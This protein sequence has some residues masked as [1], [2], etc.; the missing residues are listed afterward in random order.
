MSVVKFDKRLGRELKN[1]LLILFVFLFSGSLFANESL[2]VFLPD[3]YVSKTD[4]FNLKHAA[5]IYSSGIP[6]YNLAI[7]KSGYFNDPNVLIKSEKPM[8]IR[9]G[10]STDTL[11]LR[12]IERN[13][14]EV[15]K[16]NE[17]LDEDLKADFSDFFLAISKYQITKK[18]VLQMDYEP[19]IGTTI[20]IN[21]NRELLLEGSDFKR[22]FL[23]IFAGDFPLSRTVKINLMNEIKKEDKS[24]LGACYSF[25][26]LIGQI[27]KAFLPF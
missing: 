5:L 8:I 26:N 20:F 23:T 17:V 4:T 25:L 14:Y 16:K 12:T 3:Y 27:L 6:V 19:G 10:F 18:L 7:Y 22:G 11:Q 15:L 13:W 2:G 9:L 21:D 1:N 24:D